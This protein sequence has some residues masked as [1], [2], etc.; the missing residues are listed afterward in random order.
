MHNAKHNNILQKLVY[1]D[2][3]ITFM[4]I[5]IASEHIKFKHNFNK[6][7]KFNLAAMEFNYVFHITEDR[8]LK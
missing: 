1:Q 8:D 2:L 3:K 4:P 6:S 7:I 5:F